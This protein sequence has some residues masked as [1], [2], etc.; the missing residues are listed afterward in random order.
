MVEYATDLQ[1]RF[2]I[3]IQHWYV[4]ISC[5]SVDDTM[6]TVLCYSDL[7]WVPEDSFVEQQRR[8]RGP[9]SPWASCSVTR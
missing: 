8:A 2:E 7:L 9:R 4:S 3:D 1:K 6:L 5:D